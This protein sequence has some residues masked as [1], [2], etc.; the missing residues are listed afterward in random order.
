MRRFFFL[1]AMLVGFF[2]NFYSVAFALDGPQKPP[3]GMVELELRPNIKELIEK[4]PPAGPISAPL[5]LI[6]MRHKDS[7]SEMDMER[8]FERRESRL[9]IVTDVYRGKTTR[10]VRWL[11]F[12]G[13]VGLTK[14][15]DFGGDFKSGPFV[16]LGK[17]FVS[18]QETK[19]LRSQGYMNAATATGDF[20]AIINPKAGEKFSFEVKLEGKNTVV[21]SGG[22]FGPSTRTSEIKNYS[23]TNCTVGASKVA[24]S[25]STTLRGT[26][27]PVTCE[28]F[29]SH[30]DV[31]TV[32]DWAY[33]VDSGVYVVLRYVVGEQEL[34]YQILDAEYL[35]A[36]PVS[37]G[38][39]KLQ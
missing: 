2:G 19:N 26:Y 7:Q 34:R 20:A 16:P 5:K 27:F 37:D 1:V 30:N 36:K 35:P 28:G 39:V 11:A 18:V 31:K 15:V 3:E 12:E 21:I 6:R 22:L 10:F 13:M 25:L 32:S 17:L 23:S 8:Y 29:D 24:T 4:I 9:W 33:L 14:V 38:T